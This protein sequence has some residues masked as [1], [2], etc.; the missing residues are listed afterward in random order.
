MGGVAELH[1]QEMARLLDH[2]P[3]EVSRV[4]G[5]EWVELTTTMERGRDRGAGAGATDPADAAG[6]ARPLPARVGRRDDRRHGSG[7]RHSV[8]PDLA[9]AAGGGENPA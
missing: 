6:P 2:L 9:R 4:R 7:R 8:R 5:R 3:A 1:R